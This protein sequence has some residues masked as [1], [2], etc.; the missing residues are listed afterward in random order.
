VEKLL[1]RGEVG[2]QGKI[3]YPGEKLVSREEVVTQGRSWYPGNK[4]SPRGKGT[5]FAPP[6][7]FVL[8]AKFTPRG[9]VHPRGNLML[10]K[11]G[12]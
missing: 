9:Q 12:L 3:C 8:G 6:F 7:S 2:I 4:L 10:S 5:L 11:T 1:P